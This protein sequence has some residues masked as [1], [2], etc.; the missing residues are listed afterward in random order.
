VGREHPAPL[1]DLLARFL[2][3]G[4]EQA[5]EELVRRTQP[6][7][8]ATAR[9][10]VGSADAEDAVQTAY[11]SLLRKGRIPPDAPLMAWLLT[12]VVRIAYRHRATVQR[13]HELARRLAQETRGHGGEEDELAQLRREVGRLPASYR[14]AVVLHYLEGLS[15]AEAGKLLGVSDAA[16]WQRLHRARALLRSRLPPRFK[17]GLLF[18]PWWLADSAGAA[19][20]VVGGVMK[21]KTIVAGTLLFLALFAAGIIWQASRD[22]EPLERSASRSHSVSQP[23]SGSTDPAGTAE[24]EQGDD[25]SESAPSP[26]KG[27]H[28]S[29]EAGQPHRLAERLGDGLATALHVRVVD[30]HETPWSGAR[31]WLFHYKWDGTKNRIKRETGTDGVVEFANVASGKWQL[32]VTAG[33]LHRITWVELVGGRRVETVVVPRGGARLQGVVSRKGG[34]PLAEVSVRLWR[35]LGAFSDFL[36]ATTNEAG[37]YRIEAVPPGTYR[38]TVKGQVIGEDS[39]RC[40][41]LKIVGAEPVRRDLEVDIDAGFVSLRGVVRDA[42]MRSPISGVSV[43]LQEPV[44]RECITDPDGAYCLRD[45]PPGKGKLV[46]VKEGHELLFVDVGDFV[47]GET[48]TL[49][50]ALHPAA[51]LHFYVQ[52]EEGRPVVGRVSLCRIDSADPAGTGIS[53]TVITDANGHAAYRMIRPGRY[54]LSVRQDD[55]RSPSQKLD[56]PPGETTVHFQLRTPVPMLVGTVRDAATGRPVPGVR[57][58]AMSLQKAVVTD[59][60]GEFE[61]MR[62]LSGEEVLWV[63]K[64][65]HAFRKVR[66]AKLEEWKTRTVEV[67][68]EPGAELKLSIT[69]SKGEPPTEPV[70]L[71]F[72]PANAQGGETWN[73]S[74]EVDENGRAAYRCVP[75]GKYKL[76]VV[77]N[78]GSKVLE[79]D[80]PPAGASVD[81]RL[82]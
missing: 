74:L 29:G 26:E 8:L 17:Y 62:L 40:A 19:T 14:D 61:F 53:S 32:S 71:V 65:G 7:L 64:D 23:D 25:R 63:S 31:V 20:L 41:D 81:I 54:D 13:E 70:F 43:R 73:A 15:A 45:V 12:A 78:K 16:V 42:V 21:A 44:G 5:M 22:H 37:R 4:D 76:V 79:V 2:A 28:P 82:R 68:L 27:S 49:D 72:N 30:K 47:A 51:T 38:V 58:H 39:R 1:T 48:R 6:K 56:I 36:S 18:L 35:H 10:I 77:S 55:L 33:N 57:V 75:P 11:H 66:T 52:D 69:N 60:R 50:I 3:N 34:G 67:R 24:P 80:I 59:D 46:L 9:R